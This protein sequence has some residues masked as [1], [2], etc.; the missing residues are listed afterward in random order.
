MHSSAHPKA[1]LVEIPVQSDIYQQLTTIS[2]Q[3]HPYLTHSQFDAADSL[4]LEPN[5]RLVFQRLYQ[6]LQDHHREAGKSYWIHKCWQLS[7]W[8]PILLSLILVY[9]LNTSVP[10]SRL[11]IACR[12]SSI[13]GYS[14][15][16]NKQYRGDKQALIKHITSECL[17][18]TKSL[19]R[20]LN[21]FLPLKAKFCQR[22]LSDQLLAGLAKVQTLIPAID[23][24][25]FAAQTQLWL[26]GMQLPQT[27][28]Q[29]LSNGEIKRSSCCL[30]YRIEKTDYCNNCP[31]Q[32]AT[33]YATA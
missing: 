22:L 2:A 15:D 28:L 16:I 9:A 8:Q 19:Y 32:R 25:D 20:Q 4:A 29:T 31:K 5:N 24:D 23:N 27:L 7:I 12:H 3:V 6:N 33:P 18:L 10:L 30:E 1:A 26:S 13:F 14:L 11:K 21:E 17:L